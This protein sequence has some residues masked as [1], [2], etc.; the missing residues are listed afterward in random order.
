MDD[1]ARQVVTKLHTV[2]RPYILRRLKADVEKQMPA[3]Y[4]H[5]VVC[6]LSKRQRFLYD[7]FMSRASTKA[8][9]ASGNYLSIINCLMQLRKVCNH[10]D[11]FETRPITTSFAMPRSA[12]ADFEIRELLVRRRL[13]AEQPGARVDL[14]LL[15]L[16]PIHHEGVSSI[17]ARDT[18]RIAAMKPLAEVH[19]QQTGLVSWKM[20]YDGSS[21]ESALAAAENARRKARLAELQHTIYL[22]S[23]RHA[24]QP[25]YGK[26]LLDLLTDGASPERPPRAKT[27]L[28]DWL[29]DRSPAVSAMIPSLEARARQLQ[30]IIQKYATTTPAV[31]APGV[32]ELALTPI[33]TRLLNPSA[34]FPAYDPLHEPQ[35]RLTIAFP[36][37]RLLQYDCGK[38]QKLAVLLRQLQAG[39]HRALIF[40]QMTKMLDILEQFLNIHGYLYLRLDGATK[41]RD[42]HIYRLISE[43]TIE[44]N[45]L[46]KAN[47]KRMLDDVVIQEGNFTTDYFEQQQRAGLDVRAVLGQI[48]HQDE[49]SAAMDRVFDAKG[50]VEDKEDIDAAKNAESELARADAADFD[51]SSAANTPGYDGTHVQGGGGGGSRPGTPAATNPGGDAETGPAG[52]EDASGTTTGAKGHIDAYLLR[53]M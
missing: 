50:G 36:D 46:R 2:L 40:T 19:R 32:T 51:E 8:T 48:E 15:N 52:S 35:T 25:V 17:L 7:G 10:P 13:L 28:L 12:V 16:S 27:R 42:V 47:Q 9:L 6:K 18:A 11:L 1:E 39:G 33:S 34:V 53:L 38:L 37:K 30:P 45:I 31:V 3:K 44:T 22:Q 4:E 24:R 23:Q 49:A 43:G 41:T 21:V 26:G 14:D 29:E 20:A 5:V